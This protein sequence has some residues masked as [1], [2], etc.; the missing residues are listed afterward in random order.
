[1][2]VRR[3]RAQDGFTALFG[4]LLFGSLFLDWYPAIE[5]A[6]FERSVGDPAFAG[7]LSL[8]GTNAWEA[9]AVT[10]VALATAGLMGV[11]VALLTAI[12]RTTSIPIVW[13]TFSS[14]VTGIAA[15]WLSY[16]TL[17]PPGDDAVRGLGAVVAPT[18]VWL[19]AISCWSAMRNDRPGPAPRRDPQI[20][21][22]PAPPVAG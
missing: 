18:L 16:R 15:L 22:L 17:D 5:G 11:G 14:I 2:D 6:Y 21:R 20:E 19:L 10:D 9:F 13:T 4:A 1:V 8:H 7:V 12:S 3:L